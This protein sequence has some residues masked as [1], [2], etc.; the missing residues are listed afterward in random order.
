MGKE[1]RLR[2]SHGRGVKGGHEWME[3]G[4]DLRV[5]G[6]SKGYRWRGSDGWLR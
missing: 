2:P 4:G 5:S 6:G 1:L 3:Q